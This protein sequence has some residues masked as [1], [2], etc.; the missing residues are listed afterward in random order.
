MELTLFRSVRAIQSRKEWRLQAEKCERNRQADE[1]RIEKSHEPAQ[2]LMAS[3]RM[4]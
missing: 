4:P 3:D 2:C 1:G